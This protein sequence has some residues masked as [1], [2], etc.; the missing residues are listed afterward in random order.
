MN[1]SSWQDHHNRRMIYRNRVL[2]LFG[3]IR[4][5]FNNADQSSPPTPTIS[6]TTFATISVAFV[7]LVAFSPS[8]SNLR[9]GQGG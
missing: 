9:Y 6:S 2:L 4:Y 8:S 3:K 7:T 5:G 1:C